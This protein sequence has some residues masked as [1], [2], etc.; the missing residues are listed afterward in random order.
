[1]E[2]TYKV[3]S[4]H[5]DSKQVEERSFSELTE[6]VK[7]Y[8]Q[9]VGTAELVSAALLEINEQQERILQFYAR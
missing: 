3:L 9:L 5:N 1:M 4:Y 6:A 2:M 8:M 7:Y